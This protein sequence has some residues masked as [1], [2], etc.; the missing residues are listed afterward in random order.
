MTPPKRSVDLGAISAQDPF[1]LAFTH[2]QKDVDKSS[3][4]AP[5]VALKLSSGSSGSSSSSSISGASSEA[6]PTTSAFYGLPYDDVH[7][8]LACP[9][10]AKKK[11]VTSRKYKHSTVSE[12][13]DA[14]VK[15]I[16]E[17]CSQKVT[18]K[19]RRTVPIDVYMKPAGFVRAGFI[20]VM[21][22]VPFFAKKTMDIEHV[23]P[24]CDS[25]VARVRR[26]RGSRTR[27]S[28]SIKSSDG[29]TP[30]ASPKGARK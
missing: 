27:H 13:S 30:M 11:N 17:Y 6:R 9:E 19:V 24:K 25:C 4:V 1:Q 28:L 20:N 14:P 15:V 12:Y 26:E 18:T 7:D 29:F 22:V 21:S 3:P 8:V 5:R 23:C 2:T 10:D 16:C